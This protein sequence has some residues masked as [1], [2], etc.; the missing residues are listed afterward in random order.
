M[1]SLFD[2]YI[3]LKIA[4]KPKPASA[5]W[6]L[7]YAVQGQTGLVV[8]HQQQTQWCWAA[9]AVSISLYYN[10]ASGWTQ[11][12]LVN[13][14]LGQTTC[15]VNGGSTACNRPWYLDRA[16]IRTGNLASF[17]SGALTFGAVRTEID[18]RTPPCARIGWSGG[19]GHVVGIGAYLQLGAS[20]WLTI[21]D[22]WYGVSSQSL[23]IFQSSY[24]GSGSWTH[25]YR[26]QP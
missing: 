15:C 1:A 5:L 26:T 20:R 10:P 8:Q 16:L 23:P 18:N 6:Q 24:Q 9:V 3:P 13:A 22:P 19:G 4:L 12:D 14:E 25:T 21:C 17:S 2:V 11:C 7:F